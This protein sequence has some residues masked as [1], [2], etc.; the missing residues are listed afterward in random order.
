MT[1]IIP[2][3]LDNRV[4]YLQGKL[5]SVSKE[6]LFLKDDGHVFNMKYILCAMF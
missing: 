5:E 4:V 3:S 2:V 1:R 6:V